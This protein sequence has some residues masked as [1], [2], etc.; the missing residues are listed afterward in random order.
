MLR[1]LGLNKRL[2]HPVSTMSL[3]KRSCAHDRALRPSKMLRVE[4]SLQYKQI[5]PLAGIR[6]SHLLLGQ[7]WRIAACHA[8]GDF[9]TKPEGRRILGFLKKIIG[10]EHR[11]T[12]AK[13]LNA[14]AL[15]LLKHRVREIPL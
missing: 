1:A 3:Y 11:E 6:L 2:F 10:H 14:R 12:R 7:E 4:A 13:H 8:P 15:D 9:R 5:D